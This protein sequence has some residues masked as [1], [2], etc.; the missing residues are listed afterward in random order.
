[1]RQRTQERR[2]EAIDPGVRQAGREHIAGIAPPA[3]AIQHDAAAERTR[4]RRAAIAVAVR[5]AN[6]PGNDEGPISLPPEACRATSV[7]GGIRLKRML[8][9]RQQREWRWSLP[10]APRPGLH[11][12][13][14][15][16]APKTTHE[17]LHLDSVKC[18]CAHTPQRR[19]RSTVPGS[20]GAIAQ[21]P[22]HRGARPIP[23]A[24]VVDEETAF[25]RCP[26][27]PHPSGAAREASGL[28]RGGVEAMR[29]PMDS[30]Q[31]SGGRAQTD[32]AYSS[33][34]YAALVPASNPPTSPLPGEG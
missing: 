27:A 29:P 32:I 15:R 13:E 12:N 14:L 34:S 7:R 1:M 30:K 6:P 19:M 31:G 5:Q 24:T 3:H 25:T 17:Q 20:T 28:R 18:I 23:A 11:R 8:R 10:S 22:G 9:S 21:M 2:D 4:H 33:S 26:R 16:H